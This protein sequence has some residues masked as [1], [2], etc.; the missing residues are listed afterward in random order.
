ARRMM[1]AD[2]RRFLASLLGVGLAL[3]MVLV[4]DGLS[5]G[6]DARVTVYETRAGADLYVAQPGANSLLGSTSDV[7]R[8][9]VDQVR[10]A[11]GV[12]WAAPVRGFF[13]VPTVA[14]VKLPSYLVGWVPG[15]PGG[16][17][18]LDEGRAPATPDEIAVGR[19]FASRG[20]LAV[21]D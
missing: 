8:S 21:G 2:P 10:A 5:A 1:T 19:Q 17:W 16:P 7:P 12:Q 15:Q 3:M 4:I 18:Q 11:P 20:H 6:V 13:T 9:V 14:G